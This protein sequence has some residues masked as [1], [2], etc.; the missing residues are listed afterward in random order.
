MSDEGIF[1]ED[2]R[3]L[4]TAKDARSELPK[5]QKGKGVNH[6][7]LR[8]TLSKHI[9]RHDDNNEDDSI[10]LSRALGQ[11]KN[12]ESKKLNHEFIN[13]LVSRIKPTKTGSGFNRY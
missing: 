3:K 8:E 7:A 12:Q 10:D 11:D 13:D 5:S 9:S 4:Y 1:I 6:D 2:I